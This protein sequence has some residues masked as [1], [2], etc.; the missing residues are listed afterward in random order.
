MATRKSP[1]I[2]LPEPKADLRRPT[3]IGSAATQAG[4]RQAISPMT[5]RTA[6]LHAAMQKALGRVK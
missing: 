6:A 5:P 2:K 3:A 1:K 4:E